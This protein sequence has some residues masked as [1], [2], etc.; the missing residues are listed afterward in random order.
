[1]QTL[2]IHTYSIKSNSQNLHLLKNY[3]KVILHFNS[4]IKTYMK[5]HIEKSRHFLTERGHMVSF[6]M[7]ALA[8]AAWV[9]VF[10]SQVNAAVISTYF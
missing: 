4:L 8:V 3:V 5:Q 1:M 9:N 6:L 10:Q 7:A 2:S